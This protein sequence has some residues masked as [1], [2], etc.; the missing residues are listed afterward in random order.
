ML[1]ITLIFAIVCL[2]IFSTGQNVNADR[3]FPEITQFNQNVFMYDPTY[4]AGVPFSV[5]VPMEEWYGYNTSAKLII[6]CNWNG[7]GEH[8]II[9]EGEQYVVHEMQYINFWIDEGI[10]FAKEGQYE[11]T[12]VYEN[13]SGDKQ[14][15]GS[16]TFEVSITKT[17]LPKTGTINL[18]DVDNVDY[19]IH[20][21]LLEDI[22]IHPSGNSLIL[23]IKSQGEGE[24]SVSL[25]RIVI[26]AK[27][28]SNDIDFIV[29][30]DKKI[31][32]FEEQKTKT[33]RI[34]S[35]PF[36]NDSEEIEIIGTFVVP[37]FSNV[38]FLILSVGI[39]ATIY[40]VRGRIS[41]TS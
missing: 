26:D 3:H 41:L 4:T 10:S 19:S 28:G 27:L 12:V 23:P 38:V 31:T 30:V 35:I 16:K 2:G 39:I 11:F 7:C 32:E 40:F 22:L 15:V 29:E 25:P 13:L 24:I 34:L 36:N 6:R 21:G 8:D 17:Y 20:N 18:L 33:H 14:Q 5:T 9:F 37:E 1:R